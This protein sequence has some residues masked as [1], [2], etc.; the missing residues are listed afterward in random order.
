MSVDEAALHHRI[1]E[2]EAENAELKK[3][4]DNRKKLTHNDVRWIR[5]LA[6]N[7]RVSHAELAEMYGVGE[8]NIS[9]IVRRIY[10]PEV[11]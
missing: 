1:Q 10:Y 3:K 2:L 6:A 5:R 9:R 7:A 8:P 11:A 4:A